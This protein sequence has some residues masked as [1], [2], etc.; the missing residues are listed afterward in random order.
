V[1][2]NKLQHLEKWLPHGIKWTQYAMLHAKKTRA[3]TKQQYPNES[4]FL[5]L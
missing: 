5:T 4:P 2:L 1:V 3:P